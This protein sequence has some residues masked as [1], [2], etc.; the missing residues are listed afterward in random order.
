MQAISIRDSADQLSPAFCLRPTNVFQV[1]T[2]RSL[3]SFLA[4]SPYGK[5]PNGHL[6]A[7]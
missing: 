4:L 5:F 7:V 2:R 1:D 6:V 3:F